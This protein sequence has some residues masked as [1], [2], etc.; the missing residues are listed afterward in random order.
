[1]RLDSDLNKSAP[2]AIS[3]GYHGASDANMPSLQVPS[4]RSSVSSGLSPDGKRKIS[5][6]V[7]RDS[8]SSM[9]GSPSNKRGRFTSLQHQ[10]PPPYIVQTG[11]VGQLYVGA[12]PRSQ[13]HLLTST[14]ANQQHIAAQMAM[15][16]TPCKISDAQASHLHLIAGS[17]YLPSAA[18]GAILR[19]ALHGPAG[20]RVSMRGRS[21]GAISAAAAAPS[22]AP[23]PGY[24]AAVALASLQTNQTSQSK[25]DR[26][27]ETEHRAPASYPRTAFP[28]SSRGRCGRAGGPVRAASRNTTP[29]SAAAVDA[30]MMMKSVIPSVSP[31]PPAT[32]KASVAKTTKQQRK[33]EPT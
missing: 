11:P 7:S 17:S 4:L 33:L 18:A 10:P 12:P 13:P 3:S 20:G 31:A 27:D 1:M 30:M 32:G 14:H 25:V 6:T 8:A 16:G 29:G 28:V 24:P 22:A 26:R 23:A 5:Q 2:S 19:G 21:R 15:Q 9:G